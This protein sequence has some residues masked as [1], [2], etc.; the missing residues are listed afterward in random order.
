[1]D[2]KW[3][4]NVV[5]E[6]LLVMWYYLLNILNVIA[7]GEVIYSLGFLLFKD[8]HDSSPSKEFP[9]GPDRGLS[10]EKS[11]PCMICCDGESIKV[12]SKPSSLDRGWR[13]GSGGGVWR[14]EE[15]PIARQ[16]RVLIIIWAL[17]F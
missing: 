14:M 16:T 6:S 13:V 9:S 11:G 10:K 15:W 4:S 8:M 5:E 17:E 2:S 1:M 3:I 12:N 7:V